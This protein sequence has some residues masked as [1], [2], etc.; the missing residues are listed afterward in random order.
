MDIM[1]KRFININEL[2]EYTGISKN[3]LYS[4]VWLRK[5]PHYKP[6]KKLLKFDLREIDIWFKTQKVEVKN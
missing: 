1:E 2:S 3:T 5:I 6:N 4:W